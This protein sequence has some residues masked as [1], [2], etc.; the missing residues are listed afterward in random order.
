LIQYLYFVAILRLPVGIALILEFTGPVLV[1]L[2][3]RVVQRQQVRRR[4]WLAIGLCLAGLA[5]VVQIWSGGGGLDAVGLLAG[6]G[7]AL[8][9]AAYFLIGQHAVRGRDPL[10]L[11][12][13]AFFFATAFWAV[14][15]PWWSF[16]WSQLAVR[17]EVSGDLFAPV[18]VPVGVLVGS[19]ILL[20][21]VAPYLLSINSLR[22]VSA[23]GAGVVGTAEPVIASG[24]SWI[25]LGEELNAVQVV[26]GL[27]V[28]TGVGLAQSAKDAAASPEPLPEP[29]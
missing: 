19:V 23:T 6:A 26:G 24:V 20:G 2:Y 15:A 21:T 14:A 5:L 3:T 7:S 13:W 25:W 16:H 22:H 1:A 28:L 10:S 18:A 8:A 27:V 9:L 12:C 29:V 11:M 4:V 17:T